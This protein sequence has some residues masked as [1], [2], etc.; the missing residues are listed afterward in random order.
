MSVLG[1]GANVDAGRLAFDTQG[2]ASLKGRPAV[3][4]SAS[5]RHWRRVRANSRP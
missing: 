4:A 3:A 2:L 1:S 5:R